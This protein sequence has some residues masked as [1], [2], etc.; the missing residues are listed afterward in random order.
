MTHILVEHGGQVHG[1]AIDRIDSLCEPGTVEVLDT[2]PGRFLVA[3]NWGEECQ[4]RVLEGGE[5]TGGGN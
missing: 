3:L 1:P 2:K 4:R 5:G